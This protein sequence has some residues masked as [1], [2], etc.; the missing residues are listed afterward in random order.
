MINESAAESGKRISEYVSNVRKGPILTR[1]ISDEARKHFGYSRDSNLDFF[2]SDRKVHKP[3]KVERIANASLDITYEILNKLKA[4]NSIKKDFDVNGT[5]LVIDIEAESSF[6]GYLF[7]EGPLHVRMH[8]NPP[9][10]HNQYDMQLNF[11]E[12]QIEGKPKLAVIVESI[13]KG[14][15]QEFHLRQKARNQNKSMGEAELRTDEVE[16]YQ[17]ITKANAQLA[18]IE[19]GLGCSMSELS[20]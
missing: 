8:P 15:G 2:V 20:F 13:H 16:D 10:G 4:A 19:K 3:D 18:D 1:K 11:R 12:I 6:Y 14:Y 7:A 5:S 9:N 17:T